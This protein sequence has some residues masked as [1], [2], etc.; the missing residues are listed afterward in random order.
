M[1]YTQVLRVNRF[2]PA[3]STSKQKQIIQLDKP[4]KDEQ[5]SEVRKLLRK[6][7]VFDSKDFN[8]TFCEKDGADV[9]DDMKFELYQALIETES[10]EEARLDVYFK[11]KKIFSPIDQATQ[12]AIS[13]RLDLA[14]QVAQEPELIKKNPELLTSS[15][16]PSDWTG[17][18]GELSHAADLTEREWSVITRTNCLLSGHR[19]FTTL[20]GDGRADKHVPTGIER[21]PYNAFKIRPRM[22]EAYEISSS[23]QEDPS[24]DD[25]AKYHFRI[26]RFRVD[27][28]SSVTVFETKTSFEKS[29]ANSSFSE[30]SFQ[31]AAGASFF[32]ASVGVSAG[33]STGNTDSGTTLEAKD[34]NSL[35]INY[36]FPRVTLYWDHKSL[37]VSQECLDDIKTVV[38][39]R[40][41]NDF[42][43][44]YGHIFSRRVQL[45]GRLS[46][47][48]KV[49]ATE[50]SNVK[51]QAQRFK[52]S[53]SASVNLSF[54]QASVSAS[55]EKQSKESNSSAGRDSSSSMAWEATGG[56]TLLCNNPA[57]WCSTV[58]L[59]ENWRIVN[60]DEV[61]PLY[62]FLAKFPEVGDSIIDRFEKSAKKPSNGPLT[63]PKL[64]FQVFQ[65]EVVMDGFTDWYLTVHNGDTDI[66]EQIKKTTGYWTEDDNSA[67]ASVKYTHI[68]DMPSKNANRFVVS[69]DMAQGNDKNVR[70]GEIFRANS[71]EHPQNWSLA[72]HITQPK[73]SRKTEQVFAHLV[74]NHGSICLYNVEKPD[75]RDYIRNGDTVYLCVN[76]SNG[77]N[78]QGPQLIDSLSGLALLAGTEV[79][80][81]NQNRVPAK[82]KLFDDERLRFRFK[83]LEPYK[84]ERA[85]GPTS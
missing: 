78:P 34:D 29:M 76:N 30:T 3:S 84:G 71:L 24:R 54:F 64:N 44:K 7:N 61:I 33:A 25:G 63:S 77:I 1:A 31:V 69:K 83:I 81:P 6:N 80:L 74:D 22:F 67:K 35:V 42:H 50:K 59:Y 41:L 49:V 51:D 73:T 28:D 2:D 62:K 37:S 26:P 47:S 55:H 48:Q 70:Y 21:S 66:F 65:L 68:D 38:D 4:I 16:D 8:S 17:A 11:T 85:P 43:E 19:I 27:D 75:S 5:L 20:Q 23:G 18:K 53:A 32:G 15:F 9:G 57:K 39:P 14:F 79:W 46:S 82:A 58:S 12:D 72:S 56:D 40:T 36:N 13:E 52:A 45:G 10:T 60:Q